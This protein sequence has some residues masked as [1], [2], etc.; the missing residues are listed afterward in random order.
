VLDFQIRN[1][2]AV[3]ALAVAVP[4]SG[5]AL[6]QVSNLQSQN[7]IVCPVGADGQPIDCDAS[8]TLGECA[9][10][11]EAGPQGEPGVEGSPG[12]QG[13]P[14][15]QGP[16]GDQ[17]PQGEPGIQGD[18]GPCGPI[19]PI[20]PIG[21]QGIAG[22]AGERGPQG[23]VGA[24]GPSGP[25]GPAGASGPPGATGATGPQGLPGEPGS[26]GFGAFGSFYASSDQ[27][28]G[29][30]TSPQAMIF[31]NSLGAN[32][33][34]VTPEG[35]ILVA[36]AGFYNIQFSAQFHKDN[37]KPEDRISIWLAKKVA[38]SDEFINLPDTNT[39]VFMVERN[40]RL[41]ASWNF[42]IRVNPGDEVRLMWWGTSGNTSLAGTDAQVEP[43]R[44]AVPPVIVTVQQ[45]SN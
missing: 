10:I 45:V 36:A 24:T 1:W 43:E 2:F 25:S 44:P 8:T 41:V 12:P 29:P 40:A 14:G 22:E 31:P 38:G 33:V 27:G 32:G 9:A 5:I 15:E 39:E 34:S 13:E 17:G 21:P 23:E 28:Q 18:I 6:Y 3:V 20:G 11:G 16:K 19:G 35:S 26:T 30:S 7:N 42:I 37:T 4:T